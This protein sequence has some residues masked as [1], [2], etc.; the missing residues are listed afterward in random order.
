MSGRFSHLKPTVLMEH[1]SQICSGPASK[2]SRSTPREVRPLSRATERRPS[3][4]SFRASVSSCSVRSTA[5][6]VAPAQPVSGPSARPRRLLHRSEQ[7]LTEKPVPVPHVERTYRAVFTSDGKRALRRVAP[8][9]Y[10]PPSGYMWGYNLDRSRALFRL[11]PSPAGSSPDPAPWIDARLVRPA[12]R[13]PW[14]DSS[15]APTPIPA[16]PVCAVA[17]A[18]CS[19]PVSLACS[20]ASAS[21]PSRRR[22]SDL[23][24]TTH[25]ST[26]V[27]R[28]RTRDPALSRQEPP[29]RLR[30]CLKK[31]V[32]RPSR[33]PA[34]K[35][36]H[37]GDA[38]MTEV[39]RWIIPILHIW[40][41]P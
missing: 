8:S 35:Q 18:R 32:T 30:P 41:D 19:A 4:P 1:S 16:S 23:R 26:T 39:D 3:P 5:R 29:S 14:P 7:A 33:Q 20:A 15:P 21:P 12:P 40:P 34:K 27:A 22:L 10:P 11:A 36:V 38:T 24:S 2:T 25:R 28:T 9:M 37:W 17:S 6:R 13:I 31:G